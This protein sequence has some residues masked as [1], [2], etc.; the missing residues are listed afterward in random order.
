[1]TTSPE[2]P[3]TGENATYRV[4]AGVAETREACLALIEGAE[5]E[6]VLFS[7]DLDPLI[8]DR[9]PFVEAARR[10][11][12]LHRNNRL[13]ILLRSAQRIQKE[14]HRLIHLA[15]RLPSKLEIRRPTP[16]YEERMDDFVVVDRRGFARIKREGHLETEVDPNNR[17]E[18]GR[19][20]GHFLEIWERGVPEIDLRR[21]AL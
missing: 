5:Q 9:E 16:E 10:F 4:V 1:M 14:G 7:Q 12:L 2:K 11:V 21:L 8:F 13:L 20:H 17:L 18:A 6:V 3:D 19:L 15:Q